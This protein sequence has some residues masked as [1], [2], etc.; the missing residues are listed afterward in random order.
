MLH[1]IVAAFCVRLYGGFLYWL[2]I[3]DFLYVK[4]VITETSQPWFKILLGLPN[5]RLY[6]DRRV[7]LSLFL[8]VNPTDALRC[9]HVCLST[10][11]ILSFVYKDSL[12]LVQEWRVL[13]FAGHFWVVSGS[14]PGRI[15]F[16]KSVSEVDKKR[17]SKT[18]RQL[19]DSFETFSPRVSK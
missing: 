3:Y 13:A 8:G 12:W 1:R 17:L 14:F 11:P 10:L 16:Q 6:S 15:L 5:N 4:H 18:V 19:L 7:L 9:F 2:Q